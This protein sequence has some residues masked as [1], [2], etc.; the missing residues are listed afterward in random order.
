MVMYRL[1]GPILA[2]VL[3]CMPVSGFAAELAEGIGKEPTGISRSQWLE[4]TPDAALGF[5]L[6]TLWGV[7]RWKWF[8]QRPHIVDEHGFSNRSKTG[9][10]DKTG[11]FM[12]SY[13]ISEILTA[14][15]EGKG[16]DPKLA[17]LTGSLYASAL[18][19]WIE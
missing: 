6:I 3:S 1:I 10:S 15:L 18:M 5:G 19:T 16:Y 13:L 9:G 2:G 7:D 8:Q 14:R 17:A 11:H 12:S 4:A